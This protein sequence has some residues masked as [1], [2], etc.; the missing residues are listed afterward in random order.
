MTQSIDPARLRE[1]LLDGEELALFDV[2]EELVFGGAHIL[3]ASCL[4]LSR[5]ELKVA[6][7]AP[8]QSVRMVVCD[9]GEGLGERAAERLTQLGYTDVSVLEGGTLA[10]SDAGYELFSGV[11]VPSKAFGEMV[12]HEYGTPSISA[13]ELKSKLDAGDVVVVLDSRPYSEYHARNIPGGICVP[14]GELVYRVG[15]LTPSGD[16]LVV[17]NCAGR[18]RS[19]I[20]AQSLL[21]AGVSNQV[22]ALRN[23]TMGWHLAGYKLETGMTRRA[24][25]VS[26]KTL[27]I[28]KKR[29][30]AIAE[31]HGVK[32]I[33]KGELER[34]QEERGS[35]SLFLLDVRDP[36]EYRSGHLPG[37]RSAP[38]GQLVQE[39]DQFIGTLGAR[40]VLVDDAGVRATMTASWLNQM[41]WNEVYVLDQ[42]FEDAELE[43]GPERLEVLGLD[44]AYAPEIDPEALKAL[45]AQNAVSVLDVALSRRYREAHV[46]GAWFVLRAR[47][48]QTLPALELRDLLV[49]TSEDGVV[50]RLAAEEAVAAS[51]REVRVLAGGTA[52]WSQTGLPVESGASR[53]ADRADDLWLR[54]YEKDWGVE[55]AM[56]DYLT[57][58][59]ALVKQIERD[60]TARFRHRWDFD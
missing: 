29:A 16:A 21:N 44:N 55:Q 54:P 8:R 58:E 33:H 42:V 6:A 34:F 31:R 46:P 13:E 43:S 35:R 15:E 22:V 39:T 27:D 36:E 49:L 25:E 20:G 37:S 9:G 26:A 12:E 38:G 23:G 1:W 40:V 45:L 53:M 60:G 24:P 28:A 30:R 32:T 11:N 47:F 57:W 4:P 2:R 14:G 52:A 56:Q 7:L 18:T 19:I 48:A 51:G 3:Y 10:W 17:V 59:V 41:G 5:L 50:A